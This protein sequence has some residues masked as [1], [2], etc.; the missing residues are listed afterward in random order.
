M[1]DKI[2]NTTELDQENQ[3]SLPNDHSTPWHGVDMND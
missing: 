1:L 2:D 3:S